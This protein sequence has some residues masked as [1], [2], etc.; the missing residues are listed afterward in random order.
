MRWIS[1]GIQVRIESRDVSRV[2]AV[3]SSVRDVRRER[4]Q[5][6]KGLGRRKLINSGRRGNRDVSPGKTRPSDQSQLEL[7]VRN[8]SL[9][10]RQ[11]RQCGDH[12][13]GA[14]ACRQG[15]H[16]Q[17]LLSFLASCVS[18]VRVNAKKISAA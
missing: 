14:D 6:K 2:K 16:E 4:R 12:R 7:L 3:P 15:L 11:P 18:H 13:I 5:R 1:S 17:G 10:V 8:Q 9:L